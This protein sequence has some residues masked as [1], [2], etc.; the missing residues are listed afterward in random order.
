[1]HF[2][3]KQPST[4]VTVCN[5]AVVMHFRKY[6]VYFR[7]ISVIGDFIISASL[8]AMHLYVSCLL[9]LGIERDIIK[10]VYLSACK[11]PV[12]LFRF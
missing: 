9:Y 11:V 4:N 7:E 3:A 6:V 5:A 2:P 12:T 1:M 10:N 8:L